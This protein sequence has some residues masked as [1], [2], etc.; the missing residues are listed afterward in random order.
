MG[1]GF[2]TLP[3]SLIKSTSSGR[4]YNIVIT[5]DLPSALV[6]INIL[7]IRERSDNT[8]I[9]RLDGDIVLQTYLRISYIDSKILHNIGPHV[10]GVG[11]LFSLHLVSPLLPN[12]QPR[13]IE[14]SCSEISDVWYCAPSAHWIGELLSS[15]TQIDMAQ[16]S[17]NWRVIRPKHTN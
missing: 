4:I 8:T 10:V 5:C 6:H 14:S 9:G 3:V 7:T 13:F 2:A 11:I 12:D 17:L 15:N 1:S 16:C